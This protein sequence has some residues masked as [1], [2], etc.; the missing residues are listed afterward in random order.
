MVKHQE[1][2]GNWLRGRQDYQSHFYNRHT[3][4]E[5]PELYKSQAIYVQDLERKTW[6]PAKVEDQGNTPRSYTV[7]AETNV[8]LRRNRARN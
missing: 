5:L 8:H 6:S 2:F 3:T 7:E 1:D 4:K